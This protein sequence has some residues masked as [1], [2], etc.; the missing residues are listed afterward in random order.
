MSDVKEA[1]FFLFSN[2]KQASTFRK[3]HGIQLLTTSAP[4]SCLALSLFLLLPAGNSISICSLDLQVLGSIQGG[5]QE[6]IAPISCLFSCRK[7][8]KNIG[9]N[10]RHANTATTT[11]RGLELI[12]LH[13]GLLCKQAVQRFQYLPSAAGASQSKDVNLHRK[14]L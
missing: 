13:H 11:S 12:E 8:H 2:V 10:M 1:L 14:A 4:H 7:H 3:A 5:I 6:D 9:G